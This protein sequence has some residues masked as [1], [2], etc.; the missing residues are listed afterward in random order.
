M[1]Y[2]IELVGG[3][4]DGMEAIMSAQAPFVM[5]SEC[6]E[7]GFDAACYC[8]EERFWI[9]DDDPTRPLSFRVVEELEDEPWLGDK[10]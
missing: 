8:D 6:P 9:Y 10:A 1:K 2:R 3:K 7:H 5:V 4:W